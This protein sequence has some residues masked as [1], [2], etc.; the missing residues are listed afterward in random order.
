MKTVLVTGGAGFIG[1]HFLEHLCDR[2]AD[3]RIV[4][5]DAFTYAASIRNIPPRIL[6][7]ER[8]RLMHGDVRHADVVTELVSRADAVVHFAAESHVARSIYNN[9]LFFETD[10]IGTHVVANAVARNVDRIERFIHISS[11]EVYG[12]ASEDAPM[13]EDHPLR[14]TTPYAA[15]KAGADRLVYAYRETYDLPLVIIRPF[16]NFGPRQHLEKVIPRFITGAIMDEPLVVHG[17]GS[18]TRDWLFVEDCCDAIMRALELEDDALAALADPVIN[19]GTGVDTSIRDIAELVLD[20][21]GKSEAQIRHTAER[22]GQVHRH[23]ASTARAKEVLGF[24]SRVDLAA[25]LERTIA[26][27]RDHRDWW[28]DQLFLRSVPVVTRDG[29]TELY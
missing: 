8:F 26:W 14:P 5:L 21:M 20:L 28:E 1:S 16:N 23:I 11:S 15:A 7:D 9:T 4:V 24:E 22:P 18:S 2:W 12:T 17:D 13:G 3:A 6:N 25:G 10:V 19:L 27:Y 29:G